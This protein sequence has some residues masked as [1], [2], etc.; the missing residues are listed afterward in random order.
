MK[1]SLDVSEWVRFAK[2]DYDTAK[3]I[4]LLHHPVPLEIVC[5]HCQQ[6]AEK[7]LKAFLI[8][9]SEPLQKTHDLNILLNLCVNYDEA[10]DEYAAA[11]IRLT[12]YAVF[13]R[14]PMGEDAI[15]EYDMQT[16]LKNAYEILEFTMARLAE[17]E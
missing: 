6:S 3:N 1:D 16:A 15:T 4:S 10:F 17:T 5:Y 12:S 8:M 9:Q 2:M 7:I 11:C 14:Y 13:T